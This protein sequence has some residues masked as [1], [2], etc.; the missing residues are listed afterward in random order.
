MPPLPAPS[1]ARSPWLGIGIT[2]LAVFVFSLLDTSSK[3]LGQ[4]YPIAMVVWARYAVH[5]LLMLLVFAPRMG[6]S[7][8]HTR[9]PGMQL[10]RGLLLFSVTVLFVTGLKYIPLAE[11]TAIMY[12]TPLLVVV[13]SVPLLGERVDR[14][15][16][17]AVLAGLVGVLVVVRPGGALLSFAVL[18]PLGGALANSLYQI[19]TRKFSGSESGVTTNFITG[20]CGTLLASCALPFVWVTP[21]LADSA[22]MGLLGLCGYGGHALLIKAFDYA[23]PAS[24]APYTYSQIVSSTLIGL[25]VFEALPDAVSIAGMTLIAGSGVWV[26]LHRRRTA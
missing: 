6:G 22:V 24:L 9:R 23:S 18:L 11:A 15:T 25:W 13:F 26:A 17:L 12:L 4:R 1:A 7:L 3:Y 2:L 14:A 21:T 16:W 19:I 20:L 8:L 5:T 10:L